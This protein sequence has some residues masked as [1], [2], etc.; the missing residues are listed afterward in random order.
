[1][2]IKTLF[3][4]NVQKTKILLLTGLVIFIS[5]QTNAQLKV[6]ENPSTIHPDA[7]L[8]IKADNKGMLIPRLSLVATNNAAPLSTHAAG[9]LVYNTATSGTGTNSVS[10]G[11]YYNDGAKWVKVSNAA[12]G[13]PTKDAW[14]DDNANTQVK[15]GTLSNGAT[16]RPDA[17]AVVIKDN[18]SMGI[19][20]INP[21]GILD[22]KGKMYVNNKQTMY[23]A[24]ALDSANFWGSLFIGNGGSN[25]VHT[26]G[27]DGLYNTGVGINALTANT[28]GDANTA[29]GSYALRDNTTGR[30]NTATGTAALLSNTTGIWNTASGTAAL[31]GNTTG[32]YNTALGGYAM[33]NTTPGTLTGSHN[34]AVGYRSM[35]DITTGNRNTVVGS[36]DSIDAQGRITTG[37]NNTFVGYST[38]GGIITG[39]KNTILGANVSGLPAAL[40]N[41]IILADGDGNQRIRVLDNGNTGIGE[42]APSA[43]LEVNGNVEISTVANV[44]N[45]TEYKPLVWNTVTHRVETTPANGNNINKSI[46]L[47]AG[48]TGNLHTLTSSGTVAYE[49]KVFVANG[50]AA[51][52]YN[53]FVV[54]GSNSTSGYWSI[55]HLGGTSQNGTPTVDASSTKNSKFIHNPLSSACQDSNFDGANLDYTITVDIVTGAVTI[56]NNGATASRTYRVVIEK[57]FD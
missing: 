24:S 25:L 41:N 31:R 47:A 56:K 2:F 20:L 42:T 53:K 39:G 16:A 43:K 7:M 49:I 13:D 5:Q 37:S 11:F 15:L 26:T 30:D 21:S 48:A 45:D 38:G 19:G 14:I 36:V 34:T 32:N 55:N 12:E 3:C 50:C 35:D 17:A 28:K 9:M 57:I 10:P 52:C 6:G 18:G 1:M 4:K 23:N 51:S 46:T 33:V 40:S 27:N 29:V 8:E 22:I 44:P 54:A